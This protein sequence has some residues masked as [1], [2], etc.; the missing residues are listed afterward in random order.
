MPKF[1]QGT[2]VIYKMS[3]Y[4]AYTHYTHGIC[5]NYFHFHSGTHAAC[6]IPDKYVFKSGIHVLYTWNGWSYAWRLYYYSRGCWVSSYEIPTRQL[7]EMHKKSQH[8]H[9]REYRSTTHGLQPSWH[10]GIE[11]YILPRK[12]L[13]D[14]WNWYAHRA[15]EASYR[16]ILGSQAGNGQQ[17]YIASAALD[18]H[19]HDKKLKLYIN[20]MCNNKL[21]N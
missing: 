9:A 11:Q 7:N 14:R 16:G 1:I 15:P 8:T 12:L 2:C 18:Y 10:G 4:L 5:Y 19:H 20:Y 3:L 21:M 6:V 13:L 17:Q